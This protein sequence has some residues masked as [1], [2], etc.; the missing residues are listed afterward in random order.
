MLARI[1]RLAIAAPRR[2]LI[3]AVL[4]AAVVGAFGVPVA[5]HLSPSGF[6]DPTSQ[7]SRATAALTQKFDQGDVPLVIVVTAPDRFDAPAARKVALDV[8]DTLKRSG[9]VA[10]ITSAWTSPP[11]AAAAQ[12]SRDGKSGLITTGIVGTEAQ[13]Q[14]YTKTLTEEIDGDR[15]GIVVR[16]GGTAMV[17]LEITEQSKRDLVI[18]ESTVV[19][20]SFLVLI[21]VFGGLFAAALPVVVGVMAILGG[22]AVLRTVTLFTDVSIFALNLTTAMGLA[23]AI[24]YTLLMISRFRDELAGGAS[25]EQAVT[26]TLLTAGRTVLFSAVT[27]A[28]AM[29]VMVVFPMNFL[30]SFAYAGVATVTFASLA[31][32]V[33]TPAAIMLLGDR[34]KAMGYRPFS[35]LEHLAT[36]RMN[37]MLV[38]MATAFVAII[39]LLVAALGI[40]NTMV[41]SVLE[42]TREIGIMM[43]LGARPG[44]IRLIF[45]VEGV[46]LGLLGGLIGLGLAWLALKGVSELPDKLRSLP[47]AAMRHR[48]TLQE[49]GRETRGRNGLLRNAGR[50]LK[51]LY[52][53][54]EDLLVYLPVLELLNPLVLTGTALSIPLIIVEVLFA[55]AA[56]LG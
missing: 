31:A 19:P 55:V 30:R 48:D 20:L 13:Q 47:E 9:H 1:A 27:V 26:T 25:R 46:A 3:I 23:L 36:I 15:D 24:D 4:L 28:L 52:Q 16:S 45:L 39:A 14:S 40:T 43:A 33:V 35:L 41:M 37:V 10:G 17:N 2:V 51:L 49:I 8:I 5:Q 22:L 6:Q 29:S 54:R 53:S 7:S 42:R 32:V 44:N 38:S 50:T 34:I 21:W 11:Q 56:L 18:L 12:V